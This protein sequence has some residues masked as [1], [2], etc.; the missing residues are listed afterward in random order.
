[1]ILRRKLRHSDCKVTADLDDVFE[2]LLGIFRALFIP[3]MTLLNENGVEATD[4]N[5]NG[6]GYGGYQEAS[7]VHH[8]SNS[9]FVLTCTNHLVA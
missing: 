6:F 8:F 7:K 3:D 4:T 2:S 5:T 9:L 1:M